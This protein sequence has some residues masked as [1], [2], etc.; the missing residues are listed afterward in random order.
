[1]AEP[2]ELLGMRP[3]LWS[4]VS[5]E[6]ARGDGDMA[7]P[8]VLTR[9]HARQSGTAVANHERTLDTGRKLSK[10]VRQTERIRV[11]RHHRSR[12]ALG[13]DIG[14]P[15]ALGGRIELVGKRQRQSLVRYRNIGA[16][17]ASV[18]ERSNLV[19]NR[20]SIWRIDQVVVVLD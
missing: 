15:H 14:R 17:D 1:S 9:N 6:R 18:S 20:Q 5:R 16:S 2:P 13:Q 19:A 12:A 10:H 11:V 3:G 8:E 7:H 4:R